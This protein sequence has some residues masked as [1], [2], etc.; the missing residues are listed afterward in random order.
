M[1]GII[2][3][4]EASVYGSQRAIVVK[5]EVGGIVRGT[6]FFRGR[7][8]YDTTSN[9][10]RIEQLDFDV[11]TQEKLLD[12]ADWLLHDHLRDS[13]QAALTIPLREQ[14]EQIPKKINVAFERAKVGHKTDLALPEFRFMPQRIAVRPD[15]IQVLIKVES[16]VSVRVQ[17]LWRNRM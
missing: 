10:L 2:K 4:K 7:P 8:F 14:I 16:K 6:L 13:L 1:G 9:T 15:G 3:I 5:T 11:A 17:H 12:S